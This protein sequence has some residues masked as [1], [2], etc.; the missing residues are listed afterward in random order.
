MDSFQ[1]LILLIAVAVVLVG[2]ASRFRISYPI[3]LVLGGS[4][5]GFIPKLGTIQFDPNLMLAIVLPPILYHA[6]YRIPIKEFQRDIREILWLALGLVVATTL[7][8]AL[9]FK[10][11]FPDLPWAIAFAFGAIISPPD[12]VA[13]TVILKRFAISSR[14][15]TILEGESLINDA[16]G[17]VLYKLAVVAL[18]S[19]S[20]S[21]GDATFEFGKIVLGGMIIGVI[22][23]YLLHYISSR[24]FEP[25]VAVVFSFIIPYITFLFANWLGFSGVLAVVISGLIGARMLVTHFSSLTRIIGWAFWD[26]VIIFLNC[27]VFILI[28]L[29]LHGVVERITLDK[30]WLYLGYGVILTIATILIRFIWVYASVWINWRKKEKESAKQSSKEAMIVSWSGMR[31]I[32]S[33]TAALGLPYFMQDGASLPGR[34]IVIFLTFVVILLTLLIPGLTLFHVIQWLKIPSIREENT[35]NVRENLMK[36]VQNELSRLQAVHHLDDQEYD[37]ILTYFNHRHLMLEISTKA[38]TRSHIIE[39][40]RI[41]ILKKKREHLLEMWEKEEIS[42]ELFKLLEHEIDIEESYIIPTE[43]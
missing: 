8:I 35:K 9:I 26:I 39:F 43:I 24:F 42:D 14:L 17:L 6:A 37:I 32:V 5:L 22:S 29:S 12:A 28:G 10:G 21:L 4:F 7:I 20:F 18:L 40:A 2:L 25:I 38:K 1:I 30:A 13:A 33:L 19:G 16:T 11:L 23:G 41:Q 27:F 36:S 3:L 15:R 31:G 34:D